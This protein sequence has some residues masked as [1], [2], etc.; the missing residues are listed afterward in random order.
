[1]RTLLI[2]L[3]G[4]ASCQAP[5]PPAP[6]PDP[7]ARK[8]EVLA[9]LESLERS[10][11]SHWGSVEATKE[12]ASLRDDDIPILREVA[13]S[14]GDQALMALR[15]LA[16][17]APSE[18]FSPAAKAILY[19]TVFA[20]D[21]VVNRLGLLSKDG[22]LPGV[23]GQEVIALGPDAAPYFQQ[24]LRDV[25]RVAVL[26]EREQREGRIRQDRV[27][28]YAWAILC[29]VFGRPMQV[30]EDPRLRDDQIRELDLWLDR[31]R[32]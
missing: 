25:R 17:R 26:G 8:R 7:G 23:Y 14:N 3:L 18:H 32:K 4:L 16:K 1:M 2:L 30:V 21:V 29:T 31:R 11:Y 19:W 6:K 27:C 28:D 10:F 22:F 12:Y 5:P 13:D 9:L 20:R 24:S 15:V